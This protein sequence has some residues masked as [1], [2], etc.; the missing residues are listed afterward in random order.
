M[1]DEESGEKMVIEVSGDNNIRKE[2]I[3]YLRSGKIDYN[4][5]IKSNFF[6]SEKNKH[7]EIIG[8]WEEEY[9][10][11]DNKSKFKIMK[12]ISKKSHLKKQSV[13]GLSCEKENRKV[14]NTFLLCYVEDGDD[15]NY[16]SLK[17]RVILKGI[18]NKAIEKIKRHPEELA[19]AIFLKS[20]SDYEIK[21]I[22]N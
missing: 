14:L 20:H 17:G 6:T 19:V 13:A 15:V 3:S 11:E 22:G 1:S 21:F 4:Y 16:G 2:I 18:D 8:I 9:S 10:N 7:N 5:Q 12:V